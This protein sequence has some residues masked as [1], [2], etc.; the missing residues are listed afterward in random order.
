MRKILLYSIFLFFFACNTDSE[1][2][3]GEVVSV[4]DGDTFTMKT[5]TGERI[6]V[7]LYG[8]DAPERGQDFSNKSRQL[9]NDLCY[10]KIVDVHSQGYDQYDR[11]L[12]FVYIDGLNVNEEMVRQGLAWYYNHFVDD[13]RLD[14]LEQVAREKKLNI[15]SRKN[16]TNPYE[17]RKKQ[18][19]Q[20]ET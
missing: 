10:G 8:I 20:K 13:H 11:L 19:K 7:R 4:A 14:S 16:P 2:I 3:T 18:R 5:M 15:W 1:I 6:K 9:L 12:G 17:Y